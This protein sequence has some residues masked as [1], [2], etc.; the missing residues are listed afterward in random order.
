[1]NN[2]NAQTY[3]DDC[4][5][6]LAKVDLIIQAF[7]QF[8]DAVPF[9][10]KYAIIK[11]CGTIEQC[12]KTII[13][14]HS[15]NGQSQQVKNYIDETVRKSSMN[16]NYSN[17]CSL[18]KKFDGSWTTAFKNAV[19][20]HTDKAQIETSLSSLNEERNKFA[21]GGQPS[22]SFVNVQ[23]YFTHARK[24]IDMLDTIIV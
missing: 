24:I 17:I 19:N 1:M 5:D 16:P 3:L 7:G 6:E 14:D 9:L 2:S 13:A 22:A 12:F 18:L 20:A 8:N 23:D 10:T 21:H 15:S 11:A 4:R